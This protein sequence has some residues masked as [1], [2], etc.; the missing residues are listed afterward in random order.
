MKTI[1]FYSYKGGVGR[2][3]ALANMARFLAYFGQKV[4]VMDFDLEAPG[5][6]YKFG[7]HEHSEPPLRGVVDLLHGFVTQGK[8]PDSLEGCVFDVG[9]KQE[10]GSIHLIP[11]GDVPSV[12]YWKKLAAIDWH[13]LFYAEPNPPGVPLFEELRRLIEQTLAPDFL[14]IDSRT[15]ITEIGGVA[16]TVLPDAV[17]CLLSNNPENLEGA[18]AVLRSIRK[19]PRPEGREPV[20][21]LPV[22]T[23]IPADAGATVENKILDHVR[24]TLNQEAPDLADTLALEEIFI[25]H[26]DPSLQI[27]EVLIVED[28]LKFSNSILGKDYIHLFNRS[29]SMEF[30]NKSIIETIK[31]IIQHISVP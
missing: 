9:R 20:K 30:F 21:I 25:L 7:L 27:Q 26:S 10:H 17:V 3:L 1:T 11:A 4:V 8:V 15:G 24:T 12:G 22:V 29:F 13:G 16:T 28:V 2:T 18:R 14:L 19:A 31:E 5:L 6:H 23:R